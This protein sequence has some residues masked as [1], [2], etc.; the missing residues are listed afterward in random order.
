MTAALACCVLWQAVASAPSSDD[1][2]ARLRERKLSAAEAVAEVAAHVREADVRASALE[3]DVAGLEQQLHDAVS[4]E[5]AARAKVEARAREV[6]PR[7]RTFYRLTRRR[8]LE[9]ML[10]ADDFVTL[11]RTARG[12]SQVLLGDVESLTALQEARRA[13][14]RA[15]RALDAKKAA[16]SERL[17]QLE[18]ERSAARE[19]QG[20]LLAVVR[21]LQAELRRG[22]HAGAEA[23]QRAAGRLRGVLERPESTGFGAQK[24]QLPWP[25][26]GRVEVG[27]GRVFDA[28]LRTELLQ[29]GIHLRAP[30][31]AKVRAVCAGRVA[32]ADWVRGLG[33]V[34][35]VEHGGPY[36]TVHAHLAR[37]ERAVGD[38]V[39]A[40]DVLGLVGDTDSQKG[41]FL[42]FE[43]RQAGLAVDPL[44]WFASEEAE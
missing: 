28:R 13:Q 20:A 29:K 1:V 17:L 23:A 24:G 2:L 4:A 5:A 39:G 9:S 18:E 11:M 14:T 31:G 32:W 15:L 26:D 19:T 7:L 41:A 21:G 43:I 30:A 16:L 33:N 42:H 38:A 36:H 44:P 34:M 8:P 40:G 35:V 3:Q 12:L 25:V 37:F 6:A 22:R 10:E 27:F